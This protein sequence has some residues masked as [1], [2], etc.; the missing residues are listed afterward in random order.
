MEI[1]TI[2][3]GQLQ[4]NCYIL[5][6]KENL[7]IID[8][9]DDYNAI[10]N[11]VG[12]KHVNAILI[13]HSHSDHIGALKEILEKY[14][15]DVFSYKNLAEGSNTISNFKFKVIYTPGHTSDSIS[16]LF[17]EE[18]AIFTG[19]FVFKDTI[20]R[21]DLPTGSFISMLK[22]LNNI[23]KYENLTIYPGHGD[24]TELDYEKQHNP[25]FSIEIE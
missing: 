19:D 15:C 25:Y 21:Y 13:T 5:S 17:E 20:G 18:H 3:V 11:K 22:S 9:G 8:P 7:L 23:S 16:F 10:V 12:N 1:E 2:K 24:I 4:T 6:I 14:K